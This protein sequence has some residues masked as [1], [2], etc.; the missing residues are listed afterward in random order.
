MVL[1]TGPQRHF[2]EIKGKRLQKD[3][4]KALGTPWVVDVPHGTVSLPQGHMINQ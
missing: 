1:K 4:K 2:L 3:V